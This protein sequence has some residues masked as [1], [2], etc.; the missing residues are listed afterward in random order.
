MIMG[1]EVCALARAAA[2][3]TRR[4]S[5]NENSPIWSAQTSPRFSPGD[6]SP[7]PRSRFLHSRACA[8]THACTKRPESVRDALPLN[9]L[10]GVLAEASRVLIAV[11]LAASSPHISRR[12][13]APHRF[14]RADYFGLS[15]VYPQ[16]DTI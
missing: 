10:S 16:G 15:V 12:K 1:N 13:Q 7:S 11:P 4:G 9:Q 14:R 8:D 3:N 5:T 2:T 6:A